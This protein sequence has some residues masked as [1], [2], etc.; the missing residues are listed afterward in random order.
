MLSYDVSEEAQLRLDEYLQDIHNQK[1]TVEIAM[2]SYWYWYDFLPDVGYENSDS[3]KSD[4][5]ML[6]MML[7]LLRW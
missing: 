2:N 1:G 3:N 6:I 5:G 7:L 4:D